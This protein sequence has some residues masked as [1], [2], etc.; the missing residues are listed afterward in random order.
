M[1][2]ARCPRS[3]RGP[4]KGPLGEALPHGQASVPYYP[5][6]GDVWL[7]VV[8]G[9]M[10]ETPG[11]LAAGWALPAACCVKAASEPLWAPAEAR[12]LHRLTEPSRSSPWPSSTTP[13][14][15]H[16]TL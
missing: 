16:Q 1:A 14:A 5:R 4:L 11:H 13:P 10:Q 3:E 12:P 8:S 2:R 6:Q 7:F 9:W 15:S